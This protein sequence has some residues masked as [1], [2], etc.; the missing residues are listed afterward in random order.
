MY[1]NPSTTNLVLS[2]CY[3]EMDS[4]LV[5]SFLRLLLL[6]VIHQLFAGAFASQSSRSPLGISS[7]LLDT[8]K[9]LSSNQPSDHISSVVSVIRSQATSIDKASRISN[10]A[11][12]ACAVSK[13]VFPNGYIDSHNGANYTEAKTAHWF[14]QHA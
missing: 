6:L 11:Q 13:L 12:L 8:A 5:G 1:V 3:E 4:P 10:Q 14:V 9:S 2:F 7:I